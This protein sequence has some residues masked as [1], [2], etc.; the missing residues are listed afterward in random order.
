MSEQI[1]EQ[2]SAFLDGELPA[3]ETELLLKRLTRDAELRA[4]L[5]DGARAALA[6]TGT[7]ASQAAARRAA[8]LA[9][10]GDRDPVSKIGSRNR[11]TEPTDRH[12]NVAP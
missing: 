4:Q 9:V 11:A 3:S 2:V 7:L 8:W 5:A 1:R 10:L 6:A 12:R